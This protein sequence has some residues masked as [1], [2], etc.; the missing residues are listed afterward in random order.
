MANVQDRCRGVLLGLGAGDRNGGPVEMAV[1]LAKSLLEKGHFDQADVGRRYLAWYSASG[2]AVWDSGP[3]AAEVF[4]SARGDAAQL[5][6][7]AIDVDRRLKGMTAGSNVCHRIPP[8]AMAAFLDYEAVAAAAVSDAALTHASPL[9]AAAS[10]A[11]ALVCRGLILGQTLEE[12]T[13]AAAAHRSLEGS[14]ASP[15]REALL[16]RDVRKEELSSGGFSVDALLAA[17]HFTATASN[18]SD[19]IRAAIQFAGPAN[20]CPVICGAFL[21]GRFGAGQVAEDLFSETVSHRA[22]EYAKLGAQLNELADALS[23]GWSTA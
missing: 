16:R 11:V 9:A 10:A 6:A 3:T 14:A 22:A 13:A 21:G 7:A 23:S 17:L 2:S 12:A 18:F 4:R 8:V 19:G 15:I 5:P 1:E 20:Y